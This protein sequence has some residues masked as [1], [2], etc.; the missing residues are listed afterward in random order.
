M[1]E[2]GLREETLL[3]RLKITF[4]A[5]L[6]TITVV[7]AVSIIFN[8]TKMLKSSNFSYEYLTNWVALRLN[9]ISNLVVFFSK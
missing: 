9:I 2:E 4:L 7:H 1:G 5:F 6:C 3:G 8:C